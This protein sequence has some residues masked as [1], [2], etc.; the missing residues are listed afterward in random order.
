IAAESAG[1]GEGA[2][3]AVTLPL[4]IAGAGAPPPLASN[5]LQSHGRHARILVVDD[6]D[7][8]AESLALILRLEGNEV[9]VAR[10]GHE[11][12]ALLDEFVPEAAVLDIGLPKMSGYE[13]A[14]ALRADP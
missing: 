11:A 2:R 10:D 5:R 7:D 3:F 6:N 13:L 4:A 9:A 14:K 1:E 8:A 12:L